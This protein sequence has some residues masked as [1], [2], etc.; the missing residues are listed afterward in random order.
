MSEELTVM[1]SSLPAVVDTAMYEAEEGVGLENITSEDVAIPMLTVLQSL[2][3]E[4]K[5]IDGRYIKG[6]EEGMILHTLTKELFDGKQG[7]TVIPCYREKLIIEWRPRT[8]GGG[9][10]KVH[11]YSEALMQTTWKNDKGEY[12]NQAGNVLDL[13]MQYYCFLMKPDGSFDRVLIPLS[14][15]QLKTS[16]KWVGL[17]TSRVMKRANGSTFT[18]PIFSHAYILTTVSQSNEKGSWYGWDVQLGSVVKDPYIF[19]AVKHFH[20][21][22]KAKEVKAVTPE[23]EGTTD[24]NI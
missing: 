12:I 14:R 8:K 7:V 20:D 9:M 15:T 21:Q 6:A 16:R 1:N 17:I 23:P 18:P 19:Q 4:C 22:V 2:S 11:E 24:D 3:P 5:K 13:T 10:V